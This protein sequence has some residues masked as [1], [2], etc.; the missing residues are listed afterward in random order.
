M[1][2]F[3]TTTWPQEQ[4]PV[5]AITQWETE[6]NGE[7]IKYIQPV[8]DREIPDELYL[9]ELQD[10]NPDDYKAVYGFINE[11]GRIARPEYKRGITA[12]DLSIGWVDLPPIGQSPRLYAKIA[13]RISSVDYPDRWDSR[14]WSHIEEEALHIRMFKFMVS[15]YEEFQRSKGS[16]DPSRICWDDALPGHGPENTGQ[17]VLHFSEIL[18]LALK[19]I[20]PYISFQ[21]PKGYPDETFPESGLI[22]P[23]FR[24]QPT[25]YTAMAVQLFNHLVENATLLQCKNETCQRLFVRQRGRAEYDQ[26]RTKGVYF[27]SKQCAKA[28]AQRDYR[29]RMKEKQRK[30]AGK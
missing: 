4:L 27:C 21:Y 1:E 10:V 28:Q 16:P 30:E 15:F 6:L 9:R 29:R 14:L 24:I 19:S 3:R 20:Q 23:S 13:A 26:H 25:V 17:A 2:R 22:S 18:T 7:W 5:P 11:W 12:E 8:K